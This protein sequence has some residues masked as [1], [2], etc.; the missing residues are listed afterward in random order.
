[1]A[2]SGLGGGLPRR[3]NGKQQGEFMPRRL[4]K[5]EDLFGPLPASRAGK[6]R[7]LATIHSPPAIDVEEGR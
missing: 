4:S 3:R 1:M 5:D 6:R 7:F 2:S